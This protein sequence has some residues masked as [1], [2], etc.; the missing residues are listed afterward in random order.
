MFKWFAV[1]RNTA[2]SLFVPLTNLEHRYRSPFSRWVQVSHYSYSFAF[3]ERDRFLW[4]HFTKHFP[5]IHQHNFSIF[6]CDR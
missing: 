3:H 4:F 5:T 2:S 1:S 6:L